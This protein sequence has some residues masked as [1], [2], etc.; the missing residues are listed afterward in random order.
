MLSLS[1]M[2][3]IANAIA[4]QMTYN[5]SAFGSYTCQWIRLSSVNTSR[6]VRCRT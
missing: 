2:K 6:A 5:F 4:A 3:I 1:R